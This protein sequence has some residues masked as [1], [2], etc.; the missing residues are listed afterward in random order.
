MW[1]F[2][3]G[4]YRS[5]STLQFQITTHLVQQFDLGQVVGWIDANR[6]AEV[7]QQDKQEAGLKVIKVHKCTEAIKAEFLNNNAIGI[8]AHRDVRDVYASMMKQRQKSFEFLWNEGFLESCLEN[9]RKWTS[10]PNVLVSQYQKIIA[11]PA[12]EVRRIA[13]HLQNP[14]DQD[15]RSSVISAPLA[16]QSGGKQI[17]S[18]PLLGD[19]GGKCV[20]PVDAKTCRE[21]ADHYTIELQQE[22]IGSFKQKLLQLQRSPDDHRDIVDYHDES[23]LLHMN[24]IDAVKAGRWKQDLYPREVAQIEQTVN[25]WCRQHDIDAAIFLT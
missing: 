3:C 11:D 17:E 19:L 8:Y 21:I 10:L 22:R 23:T 25:A 2:C 4:M 1:V 9:Y 13:T 15:L 5:A 16:P 6:F 24:H 20:S 12:D 18:P 7:R 14:V